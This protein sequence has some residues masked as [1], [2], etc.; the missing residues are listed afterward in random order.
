MY[1]VE[2]LPAAY[3]DM[4]DI[5]SYISNELGNVAAAN[6]LGVGFVT[7]IDSL[8]DFPYSYPAYFPIKPLKHEYRR[9]PVGNYTVFYWVDEAEKLVVVA[10]A[11]YGKH[12]HTQILDYGQDGKR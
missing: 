2:Y 6:K 8:Q 12:N 4:V 7:A 11:I 5:V 10:R 3:R 9:L 1:K